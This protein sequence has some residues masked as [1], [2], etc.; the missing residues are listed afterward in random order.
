MSLISLPCLD[1]AG[2]LYPMS[3]TEL[4]N[5]TTG[6]TNIQPNVHVIHFPFC[7]KSGRGMREESRNP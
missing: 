4:Y 5:M 1:Y 7:G 6:T 3:E 2:A